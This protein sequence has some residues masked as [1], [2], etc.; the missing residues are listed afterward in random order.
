MLPRALVPYVSLAV[1]AGCLAAA[2][3]LV[4]AD[5]VEGVITGV[6]GGAITVRPDNG[7]E[8]HFRISNRTRIVFQSSQDAAAFP[9]VKADFLESGMRVRVNPEAMAGAAL[10]R[11]HVISVGAHA[12]PAVG[13]AATTLPAPVPSLAPAPVPGGGVVKARL[14]KIDTSRGIVDADIAGRTQSYGVKDRYRLN[15]YQEGEMVLLTFDR[16]GTVTS[17]ESATMLGRVTRVSGASVVINVDGR[18]ETYGLAKN[19]GRNLR[20]GDM[21]RFEFEDRPG[22]LKVITAIQ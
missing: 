13:G 16:N 4:A 3:R 1:A 6:D 14:K 17:I 10:D 15:R 19:V 9:N 11:V 8:Q 21:V 12:R 7:P 2:P 18:E 20:A 22:G 5:T